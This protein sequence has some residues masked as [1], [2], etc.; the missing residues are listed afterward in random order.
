M[1][2]GSYTAQ[3]T[4]EKKIR[5]TAPKKHDFRKQLGESMPGLYARALRLCKNRV[6]ADDLV[7]D[8]F[9]RALRFENTFEAGTNLQAWLQQILLSVFLTGCRRRTRE[10]RAVDSLTGD[11][12]A[13]THSNPSPAMHGLSRGVEGALR[14]LPDKFARVVELVD[15]AEH[16]YRE[17]ADELGVPVGTVMSRLFRGRRLLADALVETPLPQAA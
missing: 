13:W 7:Q 2:E 9:V 5:N 8:T 14:A 15:L 11:P 17:A 16:S 4:D 1:F 12:C 6:Q 10:R 3:A